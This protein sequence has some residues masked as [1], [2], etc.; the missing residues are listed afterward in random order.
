VDWNQTTTTSRLGRIAGV[1]AAVLWLSVAITASSFAAVSKQPRYSATIRYTEYGIPHIVAD[2]FASLGFGQGYAAARDNLCAITDGVVT[3]AG[4]RSRYHGPDAHP[5]GN[6]VWGGSLTTAPTNVSSDLYFSNIND[7]GVIEQLVAQPAPLG[8][9][10]ELGDMVRGYVA[11]FNRYRR[12]GHPSSC[13]GAAWLRPMT[14]LDVYRRFYAWSLLFG[15]GSLADALV[16]A[17]PPAGSS[18]GT[19]TGT[20][21]HAPARAAAAARELMNDTEGMGSNGIAVGGSA[22]ENGRGLILGNPHINWHGDGRLWQ[23]HLRIP[24]RLNVSGAAALGLPLVIVGHTETTAWTGTA[25]TAVPLTLFELTLVPGSPTTYVVDGQQEEMR[26]RDVTVTIK[27]ADGTLSEVSRP[28]WWTRYGPV[29]GPDLDGLPVPWTGNTAY[30]LADANTQNMRLGNLL[31]DLSQVRSSADVLDSLRET[32]GSPNFNFLATDARGDAVYADIQVVPHVTDEHAARCNTALGK[33]IFPESGL[34]VLDGARSDCAWGR[35]PDA[36]QSGTFSADRMPVLERAD[37]VENSNESHWLSNPA[38]PLT[39]FPRIFGPEATER[40]PRTRSAFTVIEDQLAQGPFTRRA[41]QDLMLAN[42]NYAGELTVASTVEMCQ[43]L[44]DGEAT[45]SR[46]NRV[47]V[48]EACTVLAR[49]DLSNDT[50]S[51]GAVLFDAYWNAITRTFRPPQWGALFDVPF[52]PSDPVNTPRGLKADHPALPTA[53]ADAVTTLTSRGIPLDAPLGE[54]QYVVRNGTKIPISGGGGRTGVFNT[55][56]AVQDAGQ[57]EIS[58]GSSYVFVTAFDGDRCPESRTLLTY[59]QSADP[60]S[61]HFSDQTKL[62]SRKR[63]VTERFC[64]HDLRD[65]TTMTVRQP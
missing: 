53:L 10:D 35:D 2:D 39:G 33:T 3:L 60:T 63:W 38:Q 56:D 48:S 49:W 5:G 52:D 32:Q 40:F 45:D 28:Q 34:A 59:S 65:A 50:G 21:S 23:V 4:E 25:S 51:R 43:S 12:E 14:E 20:T 26:R 22:T 15:Q 1:V 8:P 64:E 47:D 44:P 24:G 37:Y 13:N 27:Q 42:R 46:G 16:T 41:M 9:A 6:A 61:R 58:W 31:L 11:G 54:H 29:V 30:V 18:D 57:P 62:Y 55:I 17:Q 36:L 7:S 19:A